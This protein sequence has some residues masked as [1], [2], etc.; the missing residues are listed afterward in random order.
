MDIAAEKKEKGD[1]QE[2]KTN[3][4]LGLVRLNAV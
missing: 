1:F 4:N 2:K 3:K